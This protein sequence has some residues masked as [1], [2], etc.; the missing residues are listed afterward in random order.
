MYLGNPDVKNF[1]S[2]LYAKETRV[3]DH[4]MIQTTA[5]GLQK[6]KET[7]LRFILRMKETKGRYFK[8]KRPICK[9]KTDPVEG[10]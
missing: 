6:C 10:S 4:L 7:E 9:G 8:L 2:L 3:S 1:F 5:N